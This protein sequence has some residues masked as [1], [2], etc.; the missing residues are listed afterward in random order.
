MISVKFGVFP[1][2]CFLVQEKETFYAL[3]QRL[4]RFLKLWLPAAHNFEPSMG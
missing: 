4:A 2:V 1:F 3:K